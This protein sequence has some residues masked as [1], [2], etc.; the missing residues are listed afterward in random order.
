MLFRSAAKS[1]LQETAV[2]GVSQGIDRERAVVADLFDT[3][4]GREGFAAFID[5]R[6]P[7][8]LSG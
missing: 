6:S 3:H 8:F 5:K 7:K 4:D 2:L 1:L